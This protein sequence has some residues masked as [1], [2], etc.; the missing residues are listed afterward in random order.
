MNHTL[1][2]SHRS[3][4]D[5]GYYCPDVEVWQYQLKD[6]KTKK[7]ITKNKPIATQK[8]YWR[9]PDEARIIAISLFD[10]KEFYYHALLQYLESFKSIK[11]VNNITNRNLGL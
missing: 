11:R 5:C 4:S 1:V 9:A 6:P 8:I 7:I 2:K 3:S 10:G